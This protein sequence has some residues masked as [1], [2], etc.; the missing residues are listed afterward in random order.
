M[1]KKINKR[2]EN[3]WAGRFQEKPST[4]MVQINAS[5]EYDKKLYRQDILASKAHATMLKNQKIITKL[6][7]VFRVPFYSTFNFGKN[8]IFTVSY[9]CCR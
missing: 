2:K 4:T 1:K 3:L 7:A 8:F 5:I 6:E 9:K